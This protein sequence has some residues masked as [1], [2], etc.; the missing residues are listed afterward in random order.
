LK[1]HNGQH[2]FFMNDEHVNDPLRHPINHNMVEDFARLIRARR[3]EYPDLPMH[4]RAYF[5]I[6]AQELI[7]SHLMVND[8]D[9]RVPGDIWDLDAEELIHVLTRMYPRSSLDTQTT[10]QQVLLRLMNYIN[11]MF[12]NGSKPAAHTPHHWRAGIPIATQGTAFIVACRKILTN[13]NVAYDKH[14]EYLTGQ[15]GQ[16]MAQL[17]NRGV[18]RSNNG[19]EN[20]L[21][22]ILATNVKCGAW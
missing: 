14:R 6:P 2:A 8:G 10:D 20:K 16:Q 21:S 22:Q 17:F 11:D 19:W 15:I 9:Q 7:N 3:A 12:R 1:F 13:C 4:L 5:S 18:Q